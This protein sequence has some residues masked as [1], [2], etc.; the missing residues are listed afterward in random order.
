MIFIAQM[1]AYFSIFYLVKTLLYPIFKPVSR[2]Q[3][4]RTR[5]YLQERKANSLNNKM[6]SFKKYFSEKV[7]RKL[8]STTEINRY[9]KMIDR[10]DL[11]LNPEEIRADQILYSTIAFVVTVIMYFAN[12][13]LGYISAT[14]IILGW[15]YPLNELDKTIE[16]K[17]KN[18]SLDFPAFYSMVYYQY[19]KS[20]SIYLS[21]IVKD[22]MPNANADMAEELGVMLDNIE[23]GE[24]N[25]LKQFK[26]RV[27][28][29]Y[30]IKFCDIM[31]TRLRGYDNISQMTYLKNE[32]DD[33]R[34]R[35]LE[36]EL[37]KREL[38]NSRLQMILI[39][40][41]VVYIVIYYIFTII[42]SLKLFQ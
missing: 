8:M 30:I 17:N 34:I 14:F 18:I 9:K 2:K 39:I 36:D 23:Y 35:A 12:P 42:E 27:P 6:L 15:L 29:H 38:K 40:V 13:L 5:Q 24:E 10:L 4:Q 22:Y 11:N 32:L 37:E 41:L 20:V 25:A 1:C 16:N 26:K 7:I 19:S 28:L 33:F 21:D 31:E 3:K